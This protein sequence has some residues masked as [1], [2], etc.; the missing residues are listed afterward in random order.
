MSL[1]AGVL[2][3]GGCAWNE[4][5]RIAVGVGPGTF[6]GLRIG[7]STARALARARGIALVGVSTLESLALAASGDATGA[8]VAVLDA[9]RGE[10]FAAAWETSGPAL[11]QRLLEPVALAPETLAHTVAQLGCRC[12]MVG[13]GALA[14]RPVLAGSGTTIPDESSRLHSVDAI[15]H[16]RLASGPAVATGGDV[17]PEYL[18]LADAELAQQAAR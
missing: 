18:R 7:V 3:R 5:D 9:R 11:G 8:V 17:R 4:I 6:T 12:L 2:D 15:Y 1:I 16:C 13:D 10:V 14:F